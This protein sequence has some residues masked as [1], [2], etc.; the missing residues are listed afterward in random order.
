MSGEWSENLR[1]MVDKL[2]R[3]AENVEMVDRSIK[4]EKMRKKCGSNLENRLAE[5]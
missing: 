3:G 2:R 5:W 1:K 4:V